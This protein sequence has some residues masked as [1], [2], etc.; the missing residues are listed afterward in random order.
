MLHYSLLPNTKKKKNPISLN[1]LIEKAA[2]KKFTK[3]EI[4]TTELMILKK[5]GFKL[6]KDNFMD[7][8][9]ILF[10]KCF[11]MHERCEYKEMVF[12]LASKIY[13]MELFDLLNIRNKSIYETYTSILLYAILQVNKF[14]EFDHQFKKSAFFDDAI[15]HDISQDL[16]SIN[17]N[18][19]SRKMSYI[20][21]NKEQFPYFYEIECKM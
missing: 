18:K 5:L 11:V 13:K 7:Y 3:N 8:I 1:I 2:H 16:L 12:K 21:T 14:I 6:P 4:L 20:V 9:H 19:I 17:Y 10:N 15:A